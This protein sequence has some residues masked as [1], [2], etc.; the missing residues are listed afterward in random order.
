MQETSIVCLV[1]RKLLMNYVSQPHFPVDIEFY[2][3]SSKDQRGVLQRVGS[4]AGMA[5]V[6][7]HTM[8]IW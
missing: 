6:I 7:T 3:I 2:A 8:I 4:A 5:F 1:V